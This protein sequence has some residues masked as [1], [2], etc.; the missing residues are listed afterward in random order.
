MPLFLPN[1]PGQSPR[2]EN[3]IHPRALKRAP[4]HPCSLLQPPRRPLINKVYRPSSG[5]PPHNQMGCLGGKPVLPHPPTPQRVPRRNTGEVQGRAGLSPSRVFPPSAS[6]FCSES[7]SFNPRASP[8]W[9]PAFHSLPDARPGPARLRSPARF[10]YLY[11]LVA[12]L[13]N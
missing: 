6:S 10:Q 7:S 3:G 8:T 4:W 9:A 5:L 11:V 2:Q 12:E 1:Q 13:V